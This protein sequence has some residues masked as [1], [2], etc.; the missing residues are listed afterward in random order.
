[1]KDSLDNLFILFISHVARHVEKQ[2]VAHRHTRDDHFVCLRAIEQCP[3][4]QQG[5]RER[6]RIGNGQTVLSCSLL[7]R[8]VLALG[9]ETIE[10]GSVDRIE[11][12]RFSGSSD[13]LSGKPHVSTYGH[14]GLNVVEGHG[15]LG[16]RNDLGDMGTE[17]ITRTIR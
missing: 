17:K 11:I 3:I 14:K 1:M 8:K 15:T 4:N 6:F 10:M 13:L 16:G 5:R 2:P 12:F 9:N 7:D